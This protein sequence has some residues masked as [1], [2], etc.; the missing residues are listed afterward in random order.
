[1]TAESTL[2]AMCRRAHLSEAYAAHLLPAVRKALELPQQQRD[3]MLGLVER[4][5]VLRA[6][7]LADEEAK[8]AH[9]DRA[10]LAAVARTLHDW[11]PDEQL[12]ATAHSLARFELTERSDKAA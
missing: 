3:T 2:S 11:T 4:T 9:L 12:L 8:Y 10:L 7:G 6:E 5:L 1:M